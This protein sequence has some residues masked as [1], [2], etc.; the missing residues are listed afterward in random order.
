MSERQRLLEEN[1]RRRARADERYAPWNR[2]ER[3]MV[4]GRRRLA[5]ELLHRQG[6]FPGATTQCLEVGFGDGGWLVDLLGLRVDQASLHGVEIDLHRAARARR[7]LPA[8]HLAI[9]GGEQLPFKDGSFG[10]V[11]V[12][13]VFT[14]ILDHGLQER[15]AAEIERVVRPGGALLWYDFVVDN[16]RNKNVRGVPRRRIRALFPG[17]SGPIRAVTLAPPLL[18]RI[19]PLSVGLAELLAELPGLRTHALAVLKKD[20]PDR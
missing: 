13:T 19:A 17:L 12:S 16:P 3:L 5:A 18:R 6:V 7:R 1:A 4:D 9:T 15:L 8:A 2:A 20:R 11:V 10:L 14:S